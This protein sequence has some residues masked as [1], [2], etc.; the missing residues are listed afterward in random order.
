MLVHTRKLDVMPA[1][2]RSSLTW[3]TRYLAPSHAG[4]CA[5]AGTTAGASARRLRDTVTDVE[6]RSLDAFNKAEAPP[7]KSTR[8]PD[9]EVRNVRLTRLRIEG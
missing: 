8:L 5:A 3:P 2:T 1:P 4:S 7:S 9:R 6:T